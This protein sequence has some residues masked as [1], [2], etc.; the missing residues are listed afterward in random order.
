MDW[1]PQQMVTAEQ[2]DA[3]V[4]SSS[5]NRALQ[6]MCVLVNPSHVMAEQVAADFVVVAAK[7]DMLF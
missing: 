5:R 4:F 2:A 3:G 1:Y 7:I 6:N